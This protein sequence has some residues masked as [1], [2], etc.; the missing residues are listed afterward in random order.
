M[1]RKVTEKEVKAI[2][3][4]GSEPMGDYYLE[5]DGS[6][7]VLYLY[8]GDWHSVERLLRHFDIEESERR[9][10]Y[11]HGPLQ[12][13]SWHKYTAYPLAYKLGRG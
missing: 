7:M 2:W 8:S 3:Y 4:D 9:G 6:A 10:G 5:Q 1:S 12:K 11:G 13:E